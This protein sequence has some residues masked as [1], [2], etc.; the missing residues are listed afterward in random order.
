MRRGRRSSIQNEELLM[1]VLGG[2]SFFIPCENEKDAHSKSVSLNNARGCRL[3]SFQQKKVRIQKTLLDGEWGVKVFPARDITVFRLKD[4]VK[5]PWTSEDLKEEG[6]ISKDDQQ[7]MLMLML[8]D[9]KTHEE[10][11]AILGEEV[12]E[13]L[14]DANLMR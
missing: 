12:R 7:R 5:I 2:E 6:E 8:Q 10:I 4:G 13:K 1:E 11:I 9:G 3:P 14:T